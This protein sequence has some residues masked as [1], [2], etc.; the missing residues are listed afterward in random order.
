MKKETIII[1]V[2]AVGLLSSVVY[3]LVKPQGLE[4][5]KSDREFI[6]PDIACDEGSISDKTEALKKLTDIEV[7][8]HVKTGNVKRIAVFYR[9]LDNRQWFGVNENESFAPGSLL[10]LPLAISYY[11]LAELDPTLLDRGYEYKQ[12]YASGSLYDWQTIKP[13]ELLVEGRTYSVKELIYRMMKYSD[14]E[15][16]PVLTGSINKSFFDKVY[17]DLGV[18]VPTTLGIEE[19]FISVK[20]YA[21]ILR[22]LYNSSYLNREYSNELLGIMSESAFDTGIKAG[23]PYSIKLSNKF[24][25]RVFVDQATNKIIGLELHDCGV[26]YADPDPYVLCIMTDGDNFGELSKVISDI[27]KTIYDNH[28]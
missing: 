3:N 11:K 25:E 17:L 16:V 14:N 18:Y 23:L 1:I 6:S 19:N 5:C 7:E 12:S 2:L 10:K 28:Q 15:V 9:N 13:S 26:V 8:K 27:S 20:T 22:A 24:G 21:A 4:E